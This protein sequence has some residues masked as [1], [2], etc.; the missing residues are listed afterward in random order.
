MLIIITDLWKLVNLF[1]PPPYTISQS[2]SLPRLALPKKLVLTRCYEAPGFVKG[3]VRRFAQGSHDHRG[4]EEVSS[5]SNLLV[6][7]SI[8]GYRWI[9]RILAEWLL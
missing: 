9:T 5:S 3:Y 7:Q 4:T 8:A 1:Q 6:N 2:K